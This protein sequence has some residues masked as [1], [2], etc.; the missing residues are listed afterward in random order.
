MRRNS[1]FETIF[2]KYLSRCNG[3]RGV[4]RVRRYTNGIFTLYTKKYNEF[5]HETTHRS[6]VE[7]DNETD[8][9]YW[10]NRFVNI[11]KAHRATVR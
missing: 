5:T 4:V 10:A 9:L 6:L 1:N 2:N 8:A 7:F 3:D 11:A